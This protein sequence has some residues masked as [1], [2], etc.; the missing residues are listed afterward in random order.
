[1]FEKF[2]H[3]G[4]KSKNPIISIWLNGTISFNSSFVDKHDINNYKYAELYYNKK[5]NKV[6]IKFINDNDENSFEIVKR[7]NS[8]SIMARSFLKYY[9]IDYSRSMKFNYYFDKKIDL[10]IFNLS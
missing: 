6:G 3:K 8:R 5:D 1:M 4:M 2:E 7:G 9:S 10:F